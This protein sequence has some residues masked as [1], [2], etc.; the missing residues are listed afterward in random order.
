MSISRYPLDTIRDNVFRS[1]LALGHSEQ[2][3]EVITDVTLYAE[4][5]GNN[6][7]LIK[8]A[9]GAMK[10]TGDSNKDIE[11]VF[12]TPVSARLN[13][14]Q[15]FGLVVVS[16]AL[17]I[18]ISKANSTGISIVGCSGY[19][20]TTGALSYWSKKLADHDLIGIV[21]SQCPE[22]VAPFGS[23]EPI[24]G[25]N[26]ISIGIPTKP[27]AQILDMAT[28]AMAYYGLKTAEQEGKAIPSDVAYDAEGNETTNPTDALKGALR[29]FDRHIKGSHLALMIELLAGAFT[30]ASMENKFASKNQGTLILAINPNLMGDREGFLA[31][32]MTMC[33]R[34]KEAKKLPNVEEILLPGE[35]GDR[36]AEENLSLNSL[37]VQDEVWA[38][39]EMLA[40]SYTTT[41]S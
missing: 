17:D 31:S 41:K 32:A 22:L 24:F 7:G 21:L 23:Y 20:S 12:E 34:V 33:N 14:N 13:G 38:K 9:A 2:D 29:V 11:V 36:L 30:G 39:I 3:A 18:A 28:S 27:R 6:Q 1:L 4:L 16:K 19:S 37:P 10:P 8:V 15:R 35:R 26:P 5:R 40:R 25:T